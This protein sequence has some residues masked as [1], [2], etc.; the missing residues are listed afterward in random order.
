MFEHIST[1]EITAKVEWRSHT[2]IV[3]MLSYDPCTKSD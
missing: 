1:Q 3:R 2:C